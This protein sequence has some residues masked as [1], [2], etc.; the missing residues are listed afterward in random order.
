MTPR[1]LQIGLYGSLLAKKKRLLGWEAVSFLYHVIVCCIDGNGSQLRGGTVAIWNLL[2]QVAFLEGRCVG[3]LYMFWFL[4]LLD[5]LIPG[6]RREGIL[7]ALE[8]VLF[9]I[10]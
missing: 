5:I 8:L 7:L 2:I 9:N 6:V 3:R 10:P 1:E 4:T